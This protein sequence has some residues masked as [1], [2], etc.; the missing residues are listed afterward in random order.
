MPDT[1]K[2]SLWR[3]LALAPAAL[4]FAC[5]HNQ[6]AT[7]AD[8]IVAVPERYTA[9]DTPDAAQAAPRIATTPAPA[10]CSALGD[11]TLHGLVGRVLQD[12]LDLGAAAARLRQAEAAAA[13]AGAPLFPRIDGSVQ[14]SRTKPSALS[15]GGGAGLPFE[16]NLAPVTTYQA[17]LAVSYE[18]DVWGKVRDRKAAAALDA[19]ASAEAL[20][21]LRVTLASQ[22]AETWASLIAQRRLID[23]LERQI[24]VS[25]RFVELTRLRFSQGQGSAQD[26][27]RQQLQLEA[28]RGQLDLV[29]GRE[30]TLEGQLAVLTGTA[31]GTL[32]AL[33]ERQLPPL[34]GLPDP[35]LPLEL[36]DA[37]PDLRAARVRLEAADRRLA[38]QAKDWLPSLSFSGNLFSIARA[39]GDL[40]DDLLWQIG[41]RVS[42]TV[43]DGGARAARVEGAD[44][45]AEEQLY[46]YGQSL[47]SALQE[48]HS[49]LLANASQQQYLESLGRQL[50]EARRVLELV[51]TG[52]R[53]G[54]TAYLDVLTSLL[55]LQNLE[56]Q[57]VDAQR[58]QFAN[59]VQLCRALGYPVAASPAETGTDTVAQVGAK[60]PETETS[61][62]N[63]HQAVPSQRSAA[64]ER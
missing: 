43:F 25:E 37:R 26:I 47:L 14:G 42:E 53:E 15:F 35:G 40:V 41:G 12:N 27:G 49:A 52:Y 39:F 56:Q 1:R 45:R 6:W 9:L 22:T 11:D 63:T 36:V 4:L 5:A 30:H 34:P 50:D 44:A 31:P 13:E 17:S 3:L 48:V 59:R 29:R 16:L 28:L 24:D 46:A 10:V 54:A 8:K 61:N 20:R 57:E 2:T 62:S 64:P 19:V 18:V 38:A 51:R 32:G 23:L 7:K 21:S 33:A 58:Q 60:A 55:T